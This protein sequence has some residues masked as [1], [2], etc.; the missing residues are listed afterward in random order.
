MAALELWSV[1]GAGVDADALRGRW[2][3]DAMGVLAMLLVPLDCHPRHRLGSWWH[4]LRFALRCWWCC[5]SPW[6]PPRPTLLPG[7]CCPMPIDGRIRK[8]PAGLFTAWMV[9]TQEA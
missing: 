3:L 6:G 2:T 5:C 4:S 9:M 1:G 8:P 7:V